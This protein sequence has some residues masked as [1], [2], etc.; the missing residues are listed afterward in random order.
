VHITGGT[1]NRPLVVTQMCRRKY[2]DTGG[3]SS[4]SRLS[5]L[6]SM[7]GSISPQ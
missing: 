1:V 7:N 6:A 5:I 4:G 2:S 3:P